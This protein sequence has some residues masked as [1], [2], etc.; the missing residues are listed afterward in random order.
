LQKA[1][2][3]VSVAEIGYLEMNKMIF[4]L[5]KRY[6]FRILFVIINITSITMRSIGNRM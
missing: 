4:V 2:D 1:V 5:K 3:L 6:V